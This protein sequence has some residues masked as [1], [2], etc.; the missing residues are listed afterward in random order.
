MPRGDGSLSCRSE[1]PNT[2][3]I[4]MHFTAAGSLELKQF[5]CNPT[6]HFTIRFQLHRSPSRHKGSRYLLP[7]S[8]HACDQG[9]FTSQSIHSPVPL[10]LFDPAARLY[11]RL[12]EHRKSRQPC[13]LQSRQDVVRSSSAGCPH[14][15]PVHCDLQTQCIACVCCQGAHDH[16][17]QFHRSQPSALST[18]TV[19]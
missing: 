2:C 9:S 7:L 14:D 4:K 6:C 10:S 19:S 12:D 8:R 11:P 5:G 16:G 18:H 17:V 13:L 1:L 15:A 3:S